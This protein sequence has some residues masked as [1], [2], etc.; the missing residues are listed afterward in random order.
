MLSAKWQPFC[1]CLNVSKS[2]TDEATKYIRFAHMIQLNA[3]TTQYNMIIAHITVAS[4]AEYKSALEPM[5]R[6]P[7]TLP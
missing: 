5:K 4:E 1:L 2:S 3:V 6:P 7:D